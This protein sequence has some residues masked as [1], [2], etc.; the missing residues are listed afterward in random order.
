MLVND[1]PFVGEVVGI[2]ANYFL[3]IK[4]SDMLLHID[5]GEIEIL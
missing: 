4:T 1:E 5:S 2:D 3:Q